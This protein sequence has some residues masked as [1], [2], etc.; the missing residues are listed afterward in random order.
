MKS[1]I[2]KKISAIF[3]IIALII[4]SMSQVLAV[5]LSHD[6]GTEV[7]L[8]ISILGK[9]GWGYEVAGRIA[10]R[11][12]VNSNGSKDYSNAIY[13]LNM[14]YKF[15]TE[16]TDSDTNTT[17]NYKSSGSFSSSSITNKD[18]IQLIAE[19]MYVS[20]TTDRDEWIKEVVIP[21]MREHDA[22]WEEDSDDYI[23]DNFLNN[24]SSEYYLYDDDIF[25][26]QQCAIWHYTN[27]FDWGGGANIFFT[28]TESKDFPTNNTDAQNTKR[29]SVLSV[30]YEYFTSNNLS[31]NTSYITTTSLWEATSG[32][33]MQ[34][35]L[36]V[37]KEP[38]IYDAALTKAIIAHKKS[39]ETSYT[40]VSNREDTS[41]LE[42]GN[43]KTVTPY[44]VS[45]GDYLQYKIT[46][47]N[48]GNE[49]IKITK[50]KDYLP[51][52]L[53]MVSTSD[54]EIN[55]T[56]QWVSGT[57]TSGTKYC[58]T[59]KLK[60]TV[61]Y[62]KEDGADW[63]SEGTTPNCA[64]V[65]I[66]CKVTGE[67][68]GSSIDNVAEIT[69]MTDENGKQV[70][71]TDSTPGN[72]PEENEDDDDFESIIIG[73]QLDLVLK[74]YVTT[75]NGTS[76]NRESEVDITPLKNGEEDATYS[77]KKTNPVTVSVGDVVVYTI[78]A[79]NE[80]TKAG[81]AGEITDY[82]PE[83]LGYLPEYKLN[84]DNSWVIDTT[85][86][87]T[88]VKLNTIENG[89]ENL[90]LSDFTYTGSTV[91]ALNDVNV[92]KGAVTITTS[93]LAYT[94]SETNKLEAF[95]SSS[96]S[97]SSKSVQVA[98][99]VTSNELDSKTLENIA[100]ISKYQDEEGNQLTKDRDSTPNNKVS[101]ED[102]QDNEQ[103]QLGNKEYDLALKKFVSAVEG[104]ALET[105][106]TPVV[107][108]T[109]LNNGEDNASYTL[110]KT[111]VEVKVEDTVTY[112]IRVYNEGST[113]ATAKEI[114][115]T[116]PEGLQFIGYETEDGEFKSGNKTNYTYGW[117]MYDEDGEKTT[118][119]SEAVT[120]K[121]TY[122]SSKTID[123][124]D[125]TTLDYEDVKVEFKV[126]SKGAEKLKNIAKITDDDGDD[127]DTEDT[128]DYDTVIPEIYDLALKKFVTEV[129]DS[130]IDGRE[131]VVSINKDG[132]L[133]YA[134]T[135]DPVTIFN[136]DVVVYTIRVYNEG[137]KDAYAA[138]IVDDLPEG[139]K[140][141]TD[142]EI[143]KE[144]GW[145]MYDE[146]GEETDDIEDAIEIRTT[147]LS[148]DS[149]EEEGDNLIKA[150]NQE[151]DV[152]TYEDDE[153]QKVNNPDYRD[154]KVAFEV[155]ETNVT[156]SDRTIIN[157]ATLTEVTDEDGDPVDEED[158]ENN[159]DKEYIQL[160][161]FDL[162]LL[163]YVSKVIVI[164]DG[165]TKE[166]ET[167]YDG[168]ENPE[169]VVKVEIN[170]KK[171]ST[172]T[173]K[174]VYTL[175]V[176]NQGEIEGYANEIT[177]RIPAGMAFY[178]ED[179]TEYG[180]AITEDGIVSTDYL[181]KTLLE[182]GESAEVQITLR[183]ENSETN[184]GQK[185]NIAE[186]TD[187][188]NP[189]GASDVDSTPNNNVDGEDDQDNA[190][191]MLSITTGSTPMYIGIIITTISMLAIGGFLIKKYVL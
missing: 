127:R 183:W 150:F 21:L 107:D 144:Y 190:I 181:R 11:T 187:A 8:G 136:G 105:S 41:I 155:V 153:G 62:P 29:D 54:S 114:T 57:E 58:I 177:D 112:T 165:Q 25:F 170:R 126:V 115:D 82:I 174:Y 64:S 156:N 158:D 79:Y 130:E 159:E 40:T 38:K 77:D 188:E 106:R 175:K 65:I 162:S 86:S 59:E 131:P 16:T 42:S 10:Y 85:N 78:K 90:S 168:T 124:F 135:K 121:T 179:N 142:N 20:G 73:G 49:N 81:Y 111:P 161:Y 185:I 51:D 148:K 50:I 180:W 71:D 104:K 95:T 19:N 33:N 52:G 93:K 6:E 117:I 108:I 119:T 30:I 139:I 28:K 39:G 191:A 1:K 43:E 69:E 102:D 163:K 88:T 184:L 166:T 120:I 149:E 23:L 35:L 160:K 123:A 76:Q 87:G 91:T 116:I 32:D 137:T 27:D 7:T 75:V 157:T 172:T 167:G 151:E 109:P 31:S 5:T 132:E 55:K 99:I 17:G 14:N 37:S 147:Y 140:F 113:E 70:T 46:V 122:L 128:E 84:Y 36:Y 72:Y 96:T 26:A 118:D 15:P 66:E 182:P 60:N 68:T 44:S 189:Y 186:I 9:D 164:E 89:T 47:Y 141:L 176:T 103:L 48:Q 3:I 98:C 133:V 94:T 134:D 154:I 125:G 83:G 53:E 101:T 146:N 74:K 2:F 45:E 56:Y 13:C 92:I 63:T 24:T 22:A 138:E 110:D 152:P 97:L 169:P 34:P 61:L 67:T 12:Y 171:I 18:K 129:N 100:E 178:E 143:N 145:K 4:Q 80:G 173:V